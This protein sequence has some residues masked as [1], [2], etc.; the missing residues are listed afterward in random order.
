M[1]FRRFSV[2]LY[3]LGAIFMAHI[4]AAIVFALFRFCCRCLPSNSDLWPDKCHW[5]ALVDVAA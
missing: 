4:N 1:Y 2:L 3:I 5:I